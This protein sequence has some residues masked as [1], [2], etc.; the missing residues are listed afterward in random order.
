[1]I[2]ILVAFVMLTLV[3]VIM[4][5]C[6][7]FASNLLKES[8]DVDRNNALFQQAVAKEFQYETG[9]KLPISGDITYTFEGTDDKGGK[10]DPID[11]KIDT[12]KVT[13]VKKDTGYEIDNSTTSNNVRKIYMFSTGAP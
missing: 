5:S 12:A 7:K 11:Y 9:Y 13:F 3:M 1:M 6:M 8:T 4:Y 2:E 10:I